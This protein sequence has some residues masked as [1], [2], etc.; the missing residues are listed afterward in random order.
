MHTKRSIHGAVPHILCLILILRVSRLC[1]MA[2]GVS[3][4]VEDVKGNT[5]LF[6]AALRGRMAVVKMLLAKG[7]HSVPTRLRRK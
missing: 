5:A 1:G 3:L 6:A 7:A 2:T 4:D